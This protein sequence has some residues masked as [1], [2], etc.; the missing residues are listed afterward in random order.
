MRASLEFQGIQLGSKVWREKYERVVHMNS[1]KLHF[2]RNYFDSLLGSE[3]AASST[4]AI[5]CPATFPTMPTLENI[6]YSR[7]AT[8]AAFYDYYEFLT[9]MFLPYDFVQKPPTEGWPSITKEKLH[10]LGKNN[11]VFELIRR[12]P[13]IPDET[14][15]FS[16]ARVAHWP[17]LLEQATFSEEDVEGI[18]IMTEG[19]DWP[20]IPSSV[21]GLTCGGRN[22]DQFVLDTQLGIVYWLDTPNLKDNPIRE[23]FLDGEVLRNCLPENEQSWR[24]STAWA[25]SDL[26]EVLK[27]E[28]DILKAVPINRWIYDIE[29]WF[30]RDVGELKR[31]REYLTYL[32]RRTYQMYG[33]PTLSV[34][35][36]DACQDALDRL[37][38]SWKKMR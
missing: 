33:W 25:V 37:F 22:N 3:T 6:S 4:I 36:R 12:L 24:S 18:R 34:Y 9:K 2:P 29:E 28:F 21:F 7:E 23:P 1:Q 17:L 14:M 13:Y 10:R 8:I 31:D 30:D 11:E 26:F 20:D 38:E 27:N 35:E 16:Y 19:L 15:L 5:L 32:V